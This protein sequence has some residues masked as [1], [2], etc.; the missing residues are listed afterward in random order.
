[1]RD[2]QSPIVIQTLSGIYTVGFCIIY[3]I[4]YTIPNI[5]E[6][7]LREVKD[8]QGNLTLIILLYSFVTLNSFFHNFAFYAIIGQVGAVTFGL[9]Q[10]VRAV[11]VFFFSA[12]LFCSTQS[13]QCLTIPKILS[14]FVV[15]IGIL[16]FSYQNS[17]DNFFKIFI[18]GLQVRVKVKF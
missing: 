13:I 12:A 11:G 2:D 14:T 16:A 8:N 5:H 4:V 15:I 6:I 7:F 17:N 9:L 1:M 10:A 18:F 3:S